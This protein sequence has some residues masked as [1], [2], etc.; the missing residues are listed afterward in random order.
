MFSLQNNN[1]HFISTQGEKGGGGSGTMNIIIT[2]ECFKTSK[3][4]HTPSTFL[5]L[6]QGNR[7]SVLEEPLGCVDKGIRVRL[8]GRD[9]MRVFWV[10]K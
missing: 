5:Y 1:S 10:K 2:Q 6:A 4:Y 8:Y 7:G 3:Q 9:G